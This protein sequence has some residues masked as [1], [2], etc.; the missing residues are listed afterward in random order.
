M[1]DAVPSPDGLTPESLTPDS[2]APEI[3]AVLEALEDPRVRAVNEHHGDDHGVNLSKL[4]AVAKSLKK[5][6][7]L[8][9]ELWATGNTPARLVT[10]L[11]CRPKQFSEA[12][13][14]SMLREAY[15]P[16]VHGWLVNYV[17]KQSPHA[18]PLRL[19]WLIDDDPVVASAGWELTTER[20]M[21]SP[22]GVDL[23]MLLSIIELGM[24]DAPDRLQWAMN[25]CL[26]QIGVCHEEHRER[27]LDIGTR[28]GVLKD[29]P[30]SAGC[31]SPYAPIAI[32][33]LVKRQG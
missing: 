12:Q 15:I 24:A 25:W 23:A 30:T 28:L 5:N 26:T 18:E 20:V 33:E 4:R 32:A 31:T 14:D 16:K 8:A 2:T 17:V 13:L 3:L 7:D 1:S 22:E 9:I 19:L 11:I 10:T 29:Y 6:Q 21:K 27:A